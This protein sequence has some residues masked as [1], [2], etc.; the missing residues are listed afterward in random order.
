MKNLLPILAIVSAIVLAFFIGRW[1][2][3]PKEIIVEPSPD[4][5]I[6]QVIRDTITVEKAVIKYKYLK[7]YDTA[8]LPVVPQED[9]EP[10]DTIDNYG[11]DSVEVKIPISTYV[12]EK[13]DEY[14]IEA[15][16]YNVSFDKIQ[17]YNKT[18]IQDK[19]ITT[20][21]PAHW[22]IGI[23]AGYGATLNNNV[24]KLSPYIGIGV[25]YN[26]ITWQ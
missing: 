2:K 26:I 22:G 25:Q 13:E 9:D 6:T 10:M 17:T 7:Y 16:G 19:Y 18:I 12:A 21:K 23:Q 14:Y 24:V 5:T 3:P 4:S 20:K 15:S 1:T 8:Y 11:V